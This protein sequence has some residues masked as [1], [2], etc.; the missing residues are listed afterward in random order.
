MSALF[1]SHQ[2]GP[3]S[4]ALLE[5]CS[6]NVAEYQALIMGMELAREL[7]IRRL[8]VRGDSLLIVNQMNNVYEVR[9]PDLVPYHRREKSLAHAFTYFN[10]EHV[11]RGNNARADALAWLAASMTPSDGE[12]NNI[13]QSSKGESYHR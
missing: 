11:P 10:I 9:K 6:N 7:A 2:K 12:P 5:R 1:S 4:F 13:T 8:E 3:H